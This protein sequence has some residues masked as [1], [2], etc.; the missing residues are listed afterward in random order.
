[1]V[2]LRLPAPCVGL[3]HVNDIV[4]EVNGIPVC[5]PEQLMEVIMESDPTITLKV[6]PSYQNKVE[7]KSVR[8]LGPH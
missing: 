1:M 6:V 5:T 3:L 7:T 4:R 8:F 2:A